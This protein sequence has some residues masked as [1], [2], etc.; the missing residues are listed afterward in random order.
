[1]FLVITDSSG[2][3]KV[4]G[5]FTNDSSRKKRCQRQ[6]STED[7]W[8]IKSQF[9]MSI[10]LNA[11]MASKGSYE[12]HHQGNGEHHQGSLNMCREIC[13]SGEK[14]GEINNRTQ[15]N[16]IVKDNH[17]CSRMSNNRIHD[18]HKCI[19]ERMMHHGM[20]VGRNWS[21]M[22]KTEDSNYAPSHFP[23]H[24]DF[25]S[26]MKYNLHHVCQQMQ[27]KHTA[28]DLNCTMPY[29]HYPYIDSEHRSLQFS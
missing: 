14:H 15:I 18:D 19:E 11:N 28:S 23:Y 17:I 22:R 16:H 8:P 26:K 4:T 10:N 24:E 5:K 9:E 29:M 27:G 1:M 12:G 7:K 20:L 13:F 25:A 2:K 3:R 21:P 6:K